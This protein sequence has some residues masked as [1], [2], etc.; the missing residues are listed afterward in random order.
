VSE[1][2]TA[3]TTY[4]HEDYPHLSSEEWSC[5]NRLAIAIGNDAVGAMLLNG[6]PE[7]HKASIHSFMSHEAS[8]RSA[9]IYHETSRRREPPSVRPIKM[10]ITQYRGTE[11]ES[12]PRW[13]VEVES[14]FFA[15]QITDHNMQV[16]F[17]MSNLSG[18]A[19]SWAFGKRLADPQCFAHFGEFRQEI[20]AAFQPPKCE[21]R[22]RSKFLALKQGKRDLHAYVQEARYLVSVIV[23]D[24]MAD[25]TQVSVFINGLANGPVRTQLFRE[26]PHSL[27]DAISKAL[28]EDFSLK[29]S[30]IDGFYAP[31]GK[32]SSSNYSRQFNNYKSSYNGPEPMD[33]SYV[34]TTKDYARGKKSF[35]PSKRRP[36]E[37]NRCGKAGH[38]AYECMAPTPAPRN[39]EK[40]R[41]R[42]VNNISSSSTPQSKNESNH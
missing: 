9:M 19:R 21:F 8:V 10:D 29:Q 2:T 5:F 17:A 36:S 35:G 37:C 30:R 42:R 11:E 15:R 22:Q 25:A 38:Y 3:M 7:T 33:L 18:R 27:E 24:P 12:L 31:K 41:E 32:P 13:F 16:F 4:K 34:N 20:E 28:Q 6:T 40:R 23:Q 39:K 1:Y 14:A 26:Y